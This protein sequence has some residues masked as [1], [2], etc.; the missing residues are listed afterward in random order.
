MGDDQPVPDP[1]TLACQIFRVRNLVRELHSYCT[2]DDLVNSWKGRANSIIRDI[3]WQVEEVRKPTVIA[4]PAEPALQPP[5]AP[6]HDPL[7]GRGAALARA[8]IAPRDDQPYRPEFLTQAVVRPDQLLP[9][10]QRLCELAKITELTPQQAVELMLMTER[11]RIVDT[12]GITRRCLGFSQNKNSHSI[13]YILTGA[14]TKWYL[15]NKD[16]L[17]KLAH[18]VASLSDQILNLYDRY[19]FYPE[20]IVE[21]LSGSA[22][23]VGVF[24][25]ALTQHV[26]FLCDKENGLGFSPHLAVAMLMRGGEYIGRADQRHITQFERSIPHFEELLS[27]GI[28]KEKE[29]IC[30]PSVAIEFSDI[31]CSIYDQGRLNSAAITGLIS[32]LNGRYRPV[33]TQ[34]LVKEVKERLIPS[35]DRL[36]H[37]NAF[38]FEALS[39]II[40]RYRDLSAS[41]DNVKLLTKHSEKLI[42][43]TE[44]GIPGNLVVDILWI[45]SCY[46]VTSGR[47][48]TPAEAIQVLSRNST[49][50]IDL[51]TDASQSQPTPEQLAYHR[52]RFAECGFRNPEAVFKTVIKAGE[53]QGIAAQAP[54]AAAAAPQ[55]P[56]AAAEPAP[57][58]VPRSPSAGRGTGLTQAPSPGARPGNP[59]LRGR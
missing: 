12:A 45:E 46:S 47:F 29:I 32:A 20:T 2:H 7:V 49:T 24:I 40:C 41:I 57:N 36:L 9:K 21:A 14:A 48:I 43:L 18:E 13:C 16:Q 4:A 15:T 42:Q 22:N 52:A 44:L 39:K 34:D 19:Q 59:D 50:V 54:A 38:S 3:R 31:A 51:L 28:K 6:A 17:L 11:G 8:G 27:C 5:A 55:P 35:L 26:D 25:N 53:E 33:E 1:L 30:A 37:N 23:Q 10:T 56:I 58:P